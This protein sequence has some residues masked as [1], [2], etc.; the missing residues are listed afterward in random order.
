MN[1]AYKR[2]VQNERIIQERPITNATWKNMQCWCGE[3]SIWLPGQIRLPLAFRQLTQRLQRSQQF[4]R[5]ILSIISSPIDSKNKHRSLVKLT[6][7]TWMFSQ[8]LKAPKR[9]K[10]SLHFESKTTLFT[11]YEFSIYYTTV[12]SLPLC[13]KTFSCAFCSVIMTVYIFYA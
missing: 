5:N 4:I 12:S 6:S 3:K 10:F 11:D 8:K 1:D 7:C 9:D 13:Y 2:F